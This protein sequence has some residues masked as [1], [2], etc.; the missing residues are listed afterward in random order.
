MIISQDIKPA[1]PFFS[2]RTSSKRCLR[3]HRTIMN[4]CFDLQTTRTIRDEKDDGDV[5][6]E[7]WKVLDHSGNPFIGWV[8]NSSGLNSP[9]STPSFVRTFWPNLRA[10]EKYIDASARK[11]ANLAQ[12]EGVFCLVLS[13]PGDPAVPS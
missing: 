2:K 13:F 6:D 1:H 4:R 8:R 5:S 10:G 3:S 7:A 9:L 12:L 11:H